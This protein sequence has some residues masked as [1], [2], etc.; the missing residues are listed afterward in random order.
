[1][2]YPRTGRIVDDHSLRRIPARR[3]G[4]ANWSVIEIR[5]EDIAAGIR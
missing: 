3:N 1:M 4:N 2:E 5:R